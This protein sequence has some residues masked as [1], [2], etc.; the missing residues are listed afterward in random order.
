MRIQELVLMMVAMVGICIF[1]PL[2]QDWLQLAHV[3]EAEIESFK[4]GDGSLREIIAI[5]SS[6]GKANISLSVSKLDALLFELPGK[7]LKL[8]QG[9]VVGV[10]VVGWGVS[11]TSYSRNG[12]PSGVVPP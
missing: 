12:R 7:V 4:S 5:H 11:E 2:G 6:H 8:L 1:Q 3:L 9:D 10:S